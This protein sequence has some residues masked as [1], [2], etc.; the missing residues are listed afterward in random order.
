[1]TSCFFWTFYPVR[2]NAPLLPP[3]QAPPRKG[4][5]PGGR[6]SGPVAAA[7]LDFRIIPGSAPQGVPPRRAGFIP[8][9]DKSLTGFN[10]PL[11]FESQRLEFLTGFTNS[12]FFEDF[13]HYPFPLPLGAWSIG[14]NKKF[15]P[16]D[17]CSV[18]HSISRPLRFPYPLIILTH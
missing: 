6:P 10:A 3:G 7:G 8:L 9:R 16:I 1:M 12:I 14:F 17:G 4:S 15:L 11:G 13:F 18:F 5:C 2:K